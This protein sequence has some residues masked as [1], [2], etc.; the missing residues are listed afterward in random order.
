MFTKRSRDPLLPNSDFKISC[1]EIEIRLKVYLVNFIYIYI[2][3]YL[4]K[5]LCKT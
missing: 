2:Y 5:Y 1:T 4:C 3:L